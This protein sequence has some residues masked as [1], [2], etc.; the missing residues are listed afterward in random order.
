MRIF[1]SWYHQDARDKD[2]LLR[3]L[4]PAL[5]LFA[6]L[7]VEWWDDS[8]LTC[9][10][11]FGP[12]IVSRIDAADYGL[13]LLSTRYFSRPF[14]REHEL[15]RFAGP[16]PDKAS[17]P[18]ALSPLPPLDDTRDLGGVQRQLVFTR[19]GCSFTEQRGPDRVRFANDL[20]EAIRRR[21]T[22]GSGYRAL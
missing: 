17:L 10:E 18:V 9:G 22:T 2:A 21:A 19:H 12:T 7:T 20:A 1:L 11:E 15:P 16:E 14:I 13:L 5:G 3:D 8:H 4:V 6:D